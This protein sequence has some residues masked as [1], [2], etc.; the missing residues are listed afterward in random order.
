MSGGV[1]AHRWRRGTRIGDSGIWGA[2]SRSVFEVWSELR[3]VSALVR[4]Q[5]IS[6]APG[7]Q[8]PQ[9]PDEVRQ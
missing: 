9:V 5:R 1:W 8:G 6:R 4:L 3:S 7:A 2:C